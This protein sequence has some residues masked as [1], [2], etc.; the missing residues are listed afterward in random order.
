M[1]P[2]GD[3][4]LQ[5][6]VDEP[7][8]VAPPENA[9]WRM[10]LVDDAPD[11][12]SATRLALMGFQFEGRGLD[13]MSAYSAA[14]AKSF[15]RDAPPF[16]VA[17]IDIVMETDLAG[18]ELVQWIR[19]TLHEQRLRIVMRTGQAG[20]LSEDAATRDFDID[21]FKEK[22]ELTITK[23]RA[24]LYSKLRA[25]RHVCAL[26]AQREALEGEVAQRTA[27]L[28]NARELLQQSEKLAAIGQ[29]AA[30]VAHEINTPIGYMLSNHA[31]L[32]GYHQ[33]LLD[34]IHAYETAQ[35]HM[36]DALVRS[37]IDALKTERDLEFVKADIQ[38]LMQE[39]RQGMLRVQQI[40]R[41]LR[42]FSR[43]DESTQWQYVSL[44]Q[45]IESTLEIL[46]HELQ[47]RADVVTHL[48]AMP[49][50]PCLPAQINQVVLQ[51]LMNAAQAMQGRRG[52]ITVS[53]G[54]SAQEA[55]IK[56][57]DNGSGIAAAHLAHIFEPFFTTR[58]VGQGTGLG[59]SL[60]YGIV[61]RHHGR[62]EVQS[63][64]GAGS[65]FTVILPLQQNTASPP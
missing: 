56:V 47:A 14:Q 27:Q 42:D 37:R 1:N 57:E 4:P 23:L 11:I 38:H 48:T 7:A 17:L 31:T 18:L 6:A 16:A 58:E 28:Q 24:L 41:S 20:H 65:A 30:G 59:L 43:G 8:E 33:D 46:R 29:L 53:T 13:L 5:W 50:L 55:W 64:L 22:S 63:R 35:A 15:L 51:L 44:N 21:D 32:S 19:Q 60:A 10:L 34:V 49:D 62:I 54:C 52:T 12:H 36:G 26:A 9:P 61:Q 39:S 40:V 45:G 2:N 25:Y 3:A